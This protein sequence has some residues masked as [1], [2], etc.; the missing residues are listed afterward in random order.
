MPSPHAHMR[1][2]SK[3]KL[4]PKAKEPCGHGSHLPGRVIT[5]WRFHEGS[6]R[7]EVPV[8]LI[9]EQQYKER[10]PRQRRDTDTGHTQSAE[11]GVFITEPVTRPVARPPCWG[12]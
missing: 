5:K 12:R 4:I 9:E 6:Q 10:S 1:R 11:F 7:W 3:P 8:R 2:P